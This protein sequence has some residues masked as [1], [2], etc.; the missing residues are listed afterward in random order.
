V[1]LKTVAYTGDFCT[2]VN[3]EERN[4]LLAGFASDLRAGAAVQLR[5]RKSSQQGQ[6]QGIGAVLKKM[7][8]AFCT[9][10]LVGRRLRPNF[11]EITML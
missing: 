3:R 5:R 7:R 6:P 10:I 1:A 2:S 8:Y 11:L 9:K 4:G